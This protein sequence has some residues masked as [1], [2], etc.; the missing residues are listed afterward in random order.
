VSFVDARGRLEGEPFAYRITKDGRVRITFEGR[1]VTVVAGTR[2]ARLAAALR[3]A[4]DPIALQ[5]L[6]AKATGH[7]KHGTER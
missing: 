1:Q 5:L 4:G 6:L 3:D 2:A 7:F